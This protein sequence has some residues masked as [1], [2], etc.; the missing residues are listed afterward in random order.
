MA[1]NRIS[2]LSSHLVGATVNEKT[3]DNETVARIQ[4]LRDEYGHERAD[5]IKTKGL[6]H[7]AL[8]SSDMERTCRFYGGILGLRLTK[9]IDIGGPDAKLAGGQ[10]FFFDIGQ[11]ESLAFFWFEQGVRRRPGVASVDPVE[12]IQTGSF[13]TAAGS[14]NHVAFRVE[15]ADIDRYRQ[16][17]VDAA[18]LVSPIMYHADVPGGFETEKSDKTIFMSIYF[19]G[20]DGEYLELTA[21]REAPFATEVDIEHVPKTKKDAMKPLDR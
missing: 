4:Q 7:L 5:G 6:N 3:L 11:G 18:V 10:H 14:M 8:V 2:I 20:P 1:A 19:F 17:L 16:K 12:M 9:T 15:E 21:Q 13:A